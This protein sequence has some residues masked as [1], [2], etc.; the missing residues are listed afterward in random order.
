VASHTEAARQEELA[1]YGRDF[2]NDQRIISEIDAASAWARRY[3]VAVVATEFG[4]DDKAPPP[5]RA[6]WLATVRRSLEARGIGWTVWEYRGGFGIATDLQRG[7]AA[8]DSAAKALG[9]CGE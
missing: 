9:L 2:V 3:G 4:V 8:S 1:A 7:C 6:A 5:A